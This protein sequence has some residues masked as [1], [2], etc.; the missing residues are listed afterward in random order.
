MN[1]IDE[2][3][4]VEKKEE[5]VELDEQKEYADDEEL[6]LSDEDDAGPGLPK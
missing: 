2:M 3:V 5:E 1:N 4:I 6:D